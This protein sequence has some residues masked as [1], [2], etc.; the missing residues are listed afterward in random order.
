MELRSSKD[1]CERPR[2]GRQAR[3]EESE[4]GTLV[5]KARV[6]LEVAPKSPPSSVPSWRP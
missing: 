6:R 1:K 4:E 5:V 2:E 3:E